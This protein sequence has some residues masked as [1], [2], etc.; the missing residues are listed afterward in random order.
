MV[1]MISRRFIK[2]VFIFLP[3]F[4][5]VFSYELISKVESTSFTLGDPIYFRVTMELP[6]SVQCIPPEPE[7][8]FGSITVR[9]WN[10][11]RMEN[12][13]NDTV[14]IDYILTSYIP[15]N[16]T[17]PSLPYILQSGSLSDTLY[18]EKITLQFMTVITPPAGGADS[19]I[20]IKGLKEQQV[21]GNPPRIWLW[22]IVIVLSIWI[23]SLLI[24]F[25]TGKIR[26]KTIEPPPVPPY[27][28]AIMALGVLHGKRLLEK[29]LI[30]EYVF[31]LSEI[32]KRY[33]ER[34]FDTNASEFTTEEMI[35]WAGAS[36][37]DKK[38][39]NSIEWFFQTT[40]PVKFA[41]IIPDNETINRF[42]DEVTQFL[43]ATKPLEQQSE[44]GANQQVPAEKSQQQETPASQGPLTESS[45]NVNEVRQ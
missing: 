43:E 11:N 5:G 15:E 3:L 14:T 30:R 29:G 7:K 21:A 2:T 18:S 36:G 1:E 32:F 12:G 45:S 28:E 27:E 40:D 4:A 24:L 35:A 10:I 34:R 13:A 33:I 22:I 39:K 38:L 19:T 37:L 8:L 42:S 9:E 23:I 6:D 16:C 41:R 26:K 31:E 25:L 44:P 17:I 20:D